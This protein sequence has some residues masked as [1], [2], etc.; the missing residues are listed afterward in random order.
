LDTIAD[1]E[2]KAMTQGEGQPTAERSETPLERARANPD[3]KETL[4]R[5]IAA[6]LRGEKPVPA[7]ELTRGKQV[8][9]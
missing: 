8:G 9:R 7:T 6:R 4:R 5:S 3:L 1:Q 2:G